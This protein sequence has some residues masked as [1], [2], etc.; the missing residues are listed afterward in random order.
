VRKILNTTLIICLPVYLIIFTLYLLKV[1]SDLV[2]VTSIYAGALNIINF[3]AASLVFK[4]TLK[5]DNKKF[6]LFN[7]GGMGVRLFFLLCSIFILLNF[8]KIDIY[9]FILVF[10]VFYFVFL[11]VEVNYFHK[12]MESAKR[13]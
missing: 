12:S 9:A 6:L 13:N 1:V 2:L 8:L 3:L 10:F 7:L 4:W 5:K 11:I